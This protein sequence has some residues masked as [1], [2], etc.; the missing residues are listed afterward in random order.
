MRLRDALPT[1][2]RLGAGNLARVALYRARVKAGLFPAD[3]KDSA[4]PAGPFFAPSPAGL[5]PMPPPGDDWVRMGVA[6]GHHRFPV[7][8]APPCWFNDPLS[9]RVFPDPQR[10]WTRIGDF[11]PAF[12]DIKRV[13]EL[14]RWSWL[15]SLAQHARSDIP[16]A[17]D[18]LNQWVSD[19]CRANPPWHGPNWKCGQESSIRI[20]HAAMADLLLA[21]APRAPQPALAWWLDHSLTRIAPTMSY[22]RA[23]D[24]NHGTSEAAGLFIGGDWLGMTGGSDARAARWHRQGRAALEE[25]VGALIA[26]DGSFSQHSV[27]YHRMMLDTQSMCELWRRARCLPRFS[28]RFYAR[29]AS[30]VGWLRAMIADP[31]GD[32][33]NLGANDGAMLLPIAGNAYRDFRPSASLAGALFTDQ[34]LF[35]DDGS[36]RLLAWFGLTTAAPLVE[37]PSSALFGDGG[38]ATLRASDALA[39]LRFGRFRYRPSQ[40]DVNHVDLWVG[41]EAILRDGGTYSYNDGDEWIT[42]FGGAVGHNSVVFDGQEQMRRLGR[43]LLGDWIH[44]DI[45]PEYDDKGRLT[46]IA[47]SHRTAG[48]ARHRRRIQL[49]PKMLRVED[50]IDG[51]D[52]LAELRWRLVPGDWRIE[53]LC[54]TNGSVRIIIEAELDAALAIEAG[55]E[56]RH[57]LER[58]AVPILVVTCHAPQT[59]TT[60]VEWPA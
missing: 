1:Y 56:S 24:N 41:G 9:D 33:I 25:R 42:Y 53:G 11:E 51:F 43:F 36:S 31:G 26:D 28:D 48:G 3:A 39:V 58:T 12:G 7:T 52:R 5:P 13:W 37:P 15:P 35:A 4:V 50:R 38:Y 6:F 8:D 55:Y 45:T 19:W 16:G 46:A 60:T 20:M 32:A 47:A 49:E 57:Y 34:R 44:S 23:Q 17:I 22:A 14:S 40:C 30:A 27:T 10:R 29:A 59:V 18:R 2:W 54:A 21:D